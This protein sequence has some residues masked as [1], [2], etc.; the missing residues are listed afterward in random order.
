LN[1]WLDLADEDMSNHDNGHVDSQII[2]EAILRGVQREIPDS[3]CKEAT[4]VCA[5]S[6]AQEGGF[7]YLYHRKK[8]PQVRIYFAANP[9]EPPSQFPT[10]FS[11]NTRPRFRSSWEKRFPYFFF[12]S[13]IAGASA[14]ATFL[15]GV[16]HQAAY[17]SHRS[18]KRLELLLA[19]EIPDKAQYWE[20]VA[21]TVRVNAY[22]RSRTARAACLRHWGY[23]C[24][25]CGFDFAK[26]YGA[27]LQGF[28][29]VHHLVPLATIGQSYQLD[30]IKDMR[31]VCPNCHAAIHTREPPFTIDE[32]KAMLE[33]HGG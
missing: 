23:H 29:H 31:P 26:K 27:S 8:G 17:T 5:F 13:D 25:V 24:C 19:E 11:L 30:P 2:C 16:A 9:D 28:I 15:I 18:H 3:C 10:E 21:R 7:A 6:R 22:E 12:V 4:N 20:G 1:N 14:A 32:M 33:P